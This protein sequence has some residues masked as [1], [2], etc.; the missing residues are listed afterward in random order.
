MAVNTLFQFS[1]VSAFMEGLGDEELTVGHLK[2]K[3]DH[4]IGTFQQLDGEM[5]MLDGRVFQITADG[6]VRIKEDSDILPF[7]Q[8]TRFHPTIFRDIGPL[9]LVVLPGELANAHPQATNLFLSFKIVGIFQQITLRAIAQQQ[10]PGQKGSDLLR[11]Q[12]STTINNIEGVAFGFRSPQY[13]MHGLSVPGIHLHFVSSN[14]KFGG[15]VSGFELVKGTISS[16]CIADINLKL[17]TSVTF[18]N[19]G[20][21]TPSIMKD[22]C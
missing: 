4:G 2:S 16:A 19:A 20:L 3:G 14:E 6:T 7:A 10:Y 17:P 18:N 12:S 5:V 15:H 11:T 22:S 8:V 21:S 9:S 13:T 1:I